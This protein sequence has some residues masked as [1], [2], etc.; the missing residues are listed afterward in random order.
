[1]KR[2]LLTRELAGTTQPDQ[3]AAAGLGEGEVGIGKF[4]F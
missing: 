2:D 3:A 4:E 1:M